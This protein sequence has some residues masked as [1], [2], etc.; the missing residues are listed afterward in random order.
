MTKTAGEVCDIVCSNPNRGVA[1]Y[2]WITKSP[3][4]ADAEVDTCEHVCRN[5]ENYMSPP[6][7]PPGACKDEQCDSCY[8]WVAEGKEETE[9]NQDDETFRAEL[10][11]S[12]K[13]FENLSE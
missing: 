8:D 10:G 5:G 2:Q 9:N 1:L 7:C 11:I 13:L 3:D 12:E 4:V 6:K